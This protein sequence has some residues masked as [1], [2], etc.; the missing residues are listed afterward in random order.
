MSVCP[1]LRRHFSEQY[2]ACSQFFSHAFRHVISRPQV[3]HGLLGKYDLFPLCA[4]FI[5]TGLIGSKQR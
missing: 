3:M 5:S 2:F 1:A 4:F